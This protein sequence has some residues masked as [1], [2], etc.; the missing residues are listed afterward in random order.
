ML[1]GIDRTF[2]HYGIRQQDLN[3]ITELCDKHGLDSD[4]VTEEIL[5]SFHEKRIE[6][7]DLDDKDVV[8]VISKALQKIR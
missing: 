5:K 6:E 4:W 2:L 3:I 8:K 1:Q 7:V